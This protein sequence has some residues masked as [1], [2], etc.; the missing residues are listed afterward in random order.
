MEDNELD[1]AAYL[2]PSSG[3]YAHPSTYHTT[4]HYDSYEETNQAKQVAVPSSSS[5]TPEVVIRGG[6][7]YSFVKRLFDIF[8]SSVLIVL[9]SPLLLFLFLGVKLSS[10]GP[11]IFK[12]KR[13]GK[14]GKTIYVYKFRSMY[15]DAE[16]RL[17]DYL[18]PEQYEQW[19]K[20]RKITNDPRITKFGH[21]IRKTSLDEL[22]QL[23]NILGGSMSIV[24]PR[25]IAQYELEE[26]YTEE[27][28]KVL[29]C[30]KPGLFSNWAVNGRSNVTYEDHKRQDLELSYFGKRSIWFDLK[31]M[32][33]VIPAV[34]GHKGAQ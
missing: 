9:L 22:P 18:T 19:L 28:Q 25:P 23:F 27:E 29:L 7:G 15:I 1:S 20:D 10:K 5:K 17:H 31:L 32:F 34:L 26:N 11:A 24:G 8:V 3:A 2:N 14:N 21:I 16:S 6:K 13:V 12:D 30:A 4:S 33:M